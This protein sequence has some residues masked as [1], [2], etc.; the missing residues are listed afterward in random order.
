MVRCKDDENAVVDDGVDRQDH[1]HAQPAKQCS[2]HV[3]NR[4]HLAPGLHPLLLVVMGPI[5]KDCPATNVA[6]IPA[7]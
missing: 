3:T 4:G 1:G 5:L 6:P 7:Q 2:R